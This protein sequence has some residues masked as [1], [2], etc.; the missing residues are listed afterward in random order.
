MSYGKNPYF[1]S[2]KGTFFAKY[3]SNSLLALSKHTDRTLHIFNQ[4]N[5][6]TASNLEHSENCAQYIWRQKN[7]S[8]LATA[9]SRS[10]S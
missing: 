6:K 10:H 3:Q 2:H 4:F 5:A 9:N 1:K 8:L 7:N